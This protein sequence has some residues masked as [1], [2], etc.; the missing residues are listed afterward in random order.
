MEQDT[1]KLVKERAALLPEPIKETI[2]SGAVERTIEKMIASFGLHIDVADAIANEVT[3]SL[4]GFTEPTELPEHLKAE[5]ALDEKSIMRI[6]Q[7]LNT[8]L[9]GPLVEKLRKGVPTPP[10][11][12]KASEDNQLVETT[13]PTLPAE[14]KEIVVPD[15]HVVKENTEKKA[16]I[17]KEY[18]RDPYREPFD[19]K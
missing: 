8:E 10:E 12:E 3:L 11:N 19:E 13:P 16:P 2:L 5:T 15:A 18:V 14:K 9:Y 17:V 6:I 7:F 1:Q 4:L